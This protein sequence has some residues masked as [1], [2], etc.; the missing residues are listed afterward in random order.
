MATKHQGDVIVA[1]RWVTAVDKIEMT[2]ICDGAF[3]APPFA[4]ISD[5]VIFRVSLAKS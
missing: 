5:S 1:H 2:R 4:N 3:Y